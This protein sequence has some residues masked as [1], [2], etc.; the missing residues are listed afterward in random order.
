MI[1]RLL[2]NKVFRAK[3]ETVEFLAADSCL[4]GGGFLLGT[5]L[6]NSFVSGYLGAVFL[7]VGFFLGIRVLWKFSSDLQN[8]KT[9]VDA[10][11][12][13]LKQTSKELETNT[14]LLDSANN[15][16]INIQKDLVST[17]QDLQNARQEL[18]RML[19]KLKN[20]EEKLFGVGGGHFSKSSI[21]DPLDTM[22][23]ELKRK[24]GELEKRVDYLQS[25]GRSPY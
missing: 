5:N 10:A 22:V 3:Y 2:K 14:K 20:T 9:K 23:G 7:V 15:S 8:L 6:L 19:L 25:G 18:Q 17:Q 12:R 4:A 13:N 21:F 16:A 11:V 24:V 1:Y